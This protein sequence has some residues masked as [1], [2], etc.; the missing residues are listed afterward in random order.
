M[1]DE[2]GRRGEHLLGE[3]LHVAAAE[4]HPARDQLVEDAAEGVDVGRRA[5]VLSARLL[6]GEVLGSARDDTVRR[7]AIRP[8]LARD[9][10]E[11]EVD[12][13]HA[14]RAPFSFQEDILGLEVAMNQGKTMRGDEDIRDLSRDGD[15]LLDR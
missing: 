4:G 5:H 6:G 11:P 9:E 15:G 7:H 2:R 10:G 1:L 14:R 13:A 8:R 12:H 3:H